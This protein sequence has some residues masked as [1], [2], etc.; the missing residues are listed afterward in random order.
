MR[1]KVTVTVVLDLFAP[2][3]RSKDPLEGKCHSLRTRVSDEDLKLIS[4]CC[5][6]YGNTRSD[7]MRRALLAVCRE[8]HDGRANL[9][10]K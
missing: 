5:R 7:L 4:Q 8:L 3:T 9:Q 10:T 2:T 6:R 1:P